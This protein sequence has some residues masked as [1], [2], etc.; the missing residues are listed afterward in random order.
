MQELKISIHALR[1]EGDSVVYLFLRH[2]LTISIHALR[3]EGDGV[4]FWSG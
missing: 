2:H 1:E 4:P 3:E